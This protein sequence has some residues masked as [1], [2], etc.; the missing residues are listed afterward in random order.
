[1]GGSGDNDIEK[2]DKIFGTNEERE[3]F[4]FHNSP[5][6][7]NIISSLETFPIILKDFV[8]AK[9]CPFIIKEENPEKWRFDYRK[10][11]HIW[12]SQQPSYKKICAWPLREFLDYDDLAWS[13]TKRLELFFDKECEYSCIY[14][15]NFLYPTVTACYKQDCWYKLHKLI[16]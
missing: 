16:R 12:Y 13:D 7:K 1:M 15:D 4:I 5:P 2:E 3:S 14:D 9:N 8:R 10:I 6:N 11:D